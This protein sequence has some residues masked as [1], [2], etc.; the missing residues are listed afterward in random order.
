MSGYRWDGTHAYKDHAND[1][2]IEPGEELPDD[3]AERVSDSHPYDVE[4][5]DEADEAEAAEAEADAEDGFD[6]DEFVDQNA[7]NQ[8]DAIESGDVD[9]HLSA[10][11]DANAEEN[12]YATVEEAV[13]ERQ[14]ALDD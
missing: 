14:A 9:D 13:D 12:E 10:I 2:V 6:L 7:S 1:R 5:I 4:A 3:I 8:V 11:Q